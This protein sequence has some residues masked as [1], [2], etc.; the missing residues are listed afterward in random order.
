VDLE[1][2]PEP[3]R[4][5]ALRASDADR[6][7]VADLLGTALAEGRLSA[8]EHSER[9]DS[10]YAAKTY[11]ELELLTEDLPSADAPKISLS[12]ELPPPIRHSHSMVAIFGGAER[13]GRWLAEPQTTVTCIFGGIELDYR[14]AVLPQREVVVNVTCIF[15]G[16][17]VTIPPG[18]RVES[19]VAAI[20]GG[21]SDPGND[22]IDPDAPVI[23]LTGFVLFGGVEI[24]RKLPKEQHRALR[25]QQRQERRERQLEQRAERAQRRQDRRGC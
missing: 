16:V 11:D 6:D 12:K 18:V 4:P 13:K 20:F 7:R 25:R 9:L 19:S 1:K 15:G 3:T 10:L 24:K 14:E 22:T 2:T 21:I 17:D 5:P 8:E 23:R